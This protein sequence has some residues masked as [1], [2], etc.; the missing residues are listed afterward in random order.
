VVLPLIPVAALAIG[1]VAIVAAITTALGAFDGAKGK[2]LV[3]LGP[4]GTGKTTWATYLSTR[5][6]PDVN[7]HTNVTETSKAEVQL[8]NLELKFKVVDNSGSESAI[9]QWKKV[10]AGA[11][12][13]YYFVNA[14]Q[15]TDDRHIERIHKDARIMSLWPILDTPIT[16]MVTHADRDRFGAMGDMDSIKVRPDV[17]EIRQLLGASEVVVGRQDTEEGRRDFTMEG[18]DPFRKKGNQ[19]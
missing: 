10:S 3:L 13:I 5:V 11:D 9:G 16:L 1:A 17:V 4:K 15:L 6:I 14:S 7:K 2:T 18:L 8:K 19:K 12:R